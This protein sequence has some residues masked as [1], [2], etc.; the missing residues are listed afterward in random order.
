MADP[1]WEVVPYT[2]SNLVS[3]LAKRSPGPESKISSKSQCKYFESYFSRFKVA[4]I[5]IEYEYIDRDY[6]EDFSAYY[7]RC[8]HPYER[9]CL[10]LHFF[11]LAFSGE[12]FTKYLTGHSKDFSVSLADTY[13]G[14]I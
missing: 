1:P 6:L 11:E 13:L 3:I 10:R 5:L 2:P 9:K 14:F 4:T 8:F 7:V 12:D